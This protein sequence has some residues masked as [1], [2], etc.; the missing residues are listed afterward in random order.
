MYAIR[1]YY[2][3]DE[4]ADNPYL[5]A[6]SLGYLS[7]LAADITAHNYYVPNLM[8]KT[9]KGGRLSHVYIRNNFV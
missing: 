6:Y 7:H 1:S 3:W 4:A 5:Q 9:L 8:N 2:V